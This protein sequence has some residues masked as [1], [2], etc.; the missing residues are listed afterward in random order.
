MTSDRDREKLREGTLMEGQGEE[1][2][3][4]ILDVS[5]DHSNTTI[6]LSMTTLGISSL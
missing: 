1:M 2:L 3:L 6:I 4:Q 5:S